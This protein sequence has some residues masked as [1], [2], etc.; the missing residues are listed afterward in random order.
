GEVLLERS[1]RGQRGEQAED[2][3]ALIRCA[4]LLQQVF[5]CCCCCCCSFAFPRVR[6]CPRLVLDTSGKGVCE[7]G[8]DREAVRGRSTSASGEIC[9]TLPYPSRVSHLRERG[10]GR[11]A[12]DRLRTRTSGIPQ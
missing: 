6:L 1:Q 10:A 2:G 12:D 9:E 5:C 8:R 3:D 11:L 7:R 4:F